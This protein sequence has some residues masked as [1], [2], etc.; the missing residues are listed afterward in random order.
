M[1]LLVAAAVVAAALF[2]MGCTAN[3]SHLAGASASLPPEPHTAAALLKI[4]K[5]FNH[6]YDTGDYGPVYTRWDPRSQAIITRADYV[7]RHKDCPAVRR[8]CRRPK[9]SAGEVR[10]GPG[11]CITRS[12]VSN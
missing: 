3:S 7:K 9:V 8:R 10:M 1:R 5:V 4:A 6:D 12:A 11:W 2:T